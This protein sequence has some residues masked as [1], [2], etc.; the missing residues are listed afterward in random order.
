MWIH[1]GG[2]SG[3]T[4]SDPAFYGETLSSYGNV[5][6]VLINYRLGAFGFFYT[7]DERMSNGKNQVYS[8]NRSIFEHLSPNECAQTLFQKLQGKVLKCPRSFTFEILS[9]NFGLL[10]Q[11]TALQ[12]V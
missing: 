3:G 11:R 8:M 7:G 4:G 9:G 5:I 1:G 6:V 10:D 2:Y 12:W